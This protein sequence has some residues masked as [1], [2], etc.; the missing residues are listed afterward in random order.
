MA[1]SKKK[2]RR[3]RTRKSGVKVIR[4]TNKQG[5][6]IKKVVG[7]DGTL[8]KATRTRTGRKGATIKTT[9]E[10]TKSGGMLKTTNRTKKSG[11]SSTRTTRTND[12]GRVLRKT[13]SISNQKGKEVSAA[14]NK[15]GSAAVRT[16]NRLRDT[17]S[18][19]GKRTA[20]LKEK[21][22]A[23]RSAGDKDKVA[24][25]KERKTG[26]KNRVMDRMTKKVSRGPKPGTAKAKLA[27]T[28]TSAGKRNA[29]LTSKIK[30]ARK[31]GNKDKLASLKERRSNLRSRVRSRTNSKKK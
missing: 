6:K 17:S 7:K 10:A 16:A 14:V 23:A 21:L 30:D 18:S 25:L 9:R 22:K 2:K 24:K 8:K 12:K 3:V 11:A 27:D 15:R 20:A 19:A 13:T 1:D 5:V 26:L 4:K 28:S 29:S 31:S